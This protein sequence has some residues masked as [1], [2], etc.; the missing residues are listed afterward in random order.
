MSTSIKVTR[1]CEHCGKEFTAQTTKTRYCSH[2]CNS[3]A[4]K[5]KAKQAKV[6]RSNIDTSQ[7][8]TEPI[9]V[10]KAKEYLN[11]GEVAKLVGISKR[12]IYRLIQQGDLPRVKVRR[13]TIIRRIELEKLLTP[14][15]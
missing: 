7:K 14:N 11:I 8:R 5:Q 9:D 15:K 3:R 10:L 1:I 6:E 4:Y 12:T 13:R 2:L